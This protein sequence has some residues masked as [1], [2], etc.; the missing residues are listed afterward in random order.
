M[1]SAANWAASLARIRQREWLDP[2]LDQL[3]VGFLIIEAPTG[4]VLE[5]NRQ[6]ETI[7]RHPIRY[8]SGVADFGEWVGYHP[9]GQKYAP[10]QWPVARALSGEVTTGEDVEIQR[11]DGTRGYI[12]IDAAP[13]RDEDGSIVAALAVIQDVTDKK[14]AA[15]RLQDALESTT[16]CVYVIDREWRFTYLN[17]RA[18][19]EIANGRDLIGQN[20]WQ[21]F[22]EAAQSTFWGVYHQAMKER[23]V[24][25]FEVYYE[26]LR[27]W[28]EIHVFPSEEGIVVFFR[29]TSEQHG[30][31][32]TMRVCNRALAATSHGMIITDATQPDNPIIY[33]NPAFERLTGYAAAEVIGCNCRFLQGPASEQDVVQRMR[34]AVSEGRSFEGA[35]TNHRKDGSTFTNEI[36][37]S[38]VHDE[39]GRVTHFVGTQID[40]TPR[41]RLEEQ[42]RQSQKMEAV[43]Q[44]TGGI[45]H[46][47][48][49]L[50][51]VILGNSELLAEEIKDPGLQALARMTEETAIRAAELTQKLLAFGRRHTLKP[52]PVALDEVVHSMVGLLQRTLGAHVDIRLAAG[53]TRAAALT[54]RPLLEN[55][56]LNLA[57]NAR[58]AMPKGG[59]LTIMTGERVAGPRDGPV[60]MGQPV[61]FVT[62]ADT[63]IGMQPE[64]LERAFEPFFTTK[65]V[66]QGT[67]LGL[68]MVYGFAHQSGGHVLIESRVGEGT[69]VTIVLR[70]VGQVSEG[71]AETAAGGPVRGSGRVLVVEDEPGVRQYVETQLSSLGYE[72]TAAT[73]SREALSLIDEGRC[74]DL[75][76]TDV[77]LPQ[78]MSGV[79]LAK[80]ATTKC[81]DLKVLLTSGY[82]EEAFEQH[83]R[84][85]QGTPLLRKPYR[86]KELAE[87]V[88]GVLNRE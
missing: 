13:I 84:P 23:R 18:I 41:L 47:F 7:F 9:D 29:N 32:E 74:F 88:K 63:G 75:L 5:G 49:N 40:I 57:L 71:V 52:E 27:N 59:T 85:D 67:G 46:D 17:R 15:K 36:R 14:L 1:N 73:N 8:S 61:V 53:R 69:S 19:G 35:L 6:L 56:L 20:I 82:S 86:R 38:P 10:H 30:Y 45:A 68:A 79:E 34:L 80:I 58:D 66:G 25:S 44:L 64:V 65:D 62:V 43:G 12:S 2:I 50:L 31:Q 33:A 78:G 70:A 11:G 26:P 60:P 16:D 3:P 55:A 24:G 77:V 21:A 37:I 48:N 42:L 83:G 72:V 39:N 51:T 54:D 87:A 81:P 22:P 4:R 28:Y 76:F